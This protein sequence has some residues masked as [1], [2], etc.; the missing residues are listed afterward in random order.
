MSF[1]DSF[2]LGKYVTW[3][4]PTYLPLGPFLPI[5]RAW[6]AAGPQSNI[7]PWG[8]EKTKTKTKTRETMGRFQTN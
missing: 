8:R 1:K 6:V 7:M 4:A 2:T 5:V 3:V